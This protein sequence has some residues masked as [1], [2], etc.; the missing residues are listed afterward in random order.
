MFLLIDNLVSEFYRK[1]PNMV[2]FEKSVDK[3]FLLWRKY[4][5]TKSSS[6]RNQLVVMYLELPKHHARKFLCR[7]PKSIGYDDLFSAGCIGLIK[8]VEAYEVERGVMFNTYAA[9]CIRGAIFDYLRNTDHVSIHTRRKSS[10]YR[11]TLALLRCKLEHE[12]TEEEMANYLKISLDKVHD[13]QHSAMISDIQIFQETEWEEN[14]GTDDVIKNGHSFYQMGEI[15]DSKL[16]HPLDKLVEKES[17]CRLISCLNQRERFIITLY[18]RHNFTMR[19]IG[20]TLGL[21]L[22]RVS[23]IH[24]EALQ[25]IKSSFC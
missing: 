20:K 5:Q 13:L 21:S 17:F 10:I 14:K 18:Y 6:L 8:A 16:E 25:M 19:R 2:V 11:E 23:Q 22:S 4:K 7:L 24:S 15:A 12:P 9:P 3:E 1:E